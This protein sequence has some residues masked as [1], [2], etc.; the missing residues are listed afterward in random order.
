[1]H[2]TRIEN[3]A[4]N[5]GKPVRE[6]F[7]D[8]SRPVLGEEEKNE[9]MKVLDSGWLTSGDKVKEF[10][11]RFAYYIGS[12]YAISVNSC[13]AGL[14]LIL[15]V[16]GIG[17]GDEVITSPNTFPA[18]ANVIEHLGAKPV[19]CDIKL[20]DGNIDPDKIAEKITSRTK[21]IIPVHYAGAPCDMDAIETLAFNYRLFI[22]NDAAH[23]IETEWVDGKIGRHGIASAYS[24]YATKNLTTGEGG[25]VVTNNENIA[26][27]L[28]LLRLH[29][30]SDDA[31]SRY[32]KSGKSSYDLILPGYKFNMP[33][34]LA[35]L[36]LVQ[37]KKIYS[38]HQLRFELD[39]YYRSL[40]QDVEYV[41]TLRKVNKGAHAYHLF[42]V[43]VDFDK[44]S[45]DKDEFID[46]L[47]SEN[48]G[49]SQHFK[50][51][52]LYTYYRN[53]YGYK[54]GDFPLAEQ[55][56]QRV[57]TLPFSP[58]ISKNDVM[59][60]VNALKKVLDHYCKFRKLYSFE[61]MERL[62]SRTLY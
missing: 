30:L 60:V 39:E 13:T 5:G 14:F 22:V 16:L 2:G 10:E 18:T 7:L 27:Q 1:M 57:I 29:G 28:T 19:F 3:L 32:Q 20:D 8:F 26:R 37:L 56:G 23:A 25:M 50:P 54:E 48:I 15:K 47:K 36:G 52:H 44:L 61:I 41:T 62:E 55:F 34:I 53:K 35:A 12:K 58:Y 17:A 9:V 42:P 59:D 38:H 51:L 45:C 43:L 49:A 21:G 31:S 6:N 11:K 46:A 33:D 40:L 4:I 24:F